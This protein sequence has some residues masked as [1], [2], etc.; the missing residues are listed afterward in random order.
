LYAKT[1]GEIKTVFLAGKL[2]PELMLTFADA[3]SHTFDAS[4]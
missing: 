1:I 4:A 2:A 3:E